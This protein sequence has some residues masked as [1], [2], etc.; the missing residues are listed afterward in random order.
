M[1]NAIQSCCLFLF[2]ALLCQGAGAFSLFAQTPDEQPALLFLPAVASQAGATRTPVPIPS[3][4]TTTRTTTLYAGPGNVDYGALTTLVTGTALT[5]LGIYG[6]FVQVETAAADTPTTGYLWRK[7]L[8]TLPASLPELTT[9]AVPWVERLLVPETYPLTF[10]LFDPDNYRVYPL[11][12]SATLADGDITLQVSLQAQPQS[13]A[14]ADAANG[15]Y[16]GTGER[17]LYLAYQGGN[18]KFIY[19]EGDTYP[20]ARDFPALTAPTVELTLKLMQQN[21]L[22]TVGLPTGEEVSI[23]LGQSLFAPD[24]TLYLFAQTAPAST[25]TLLAAQLVQ[26]PSGRYEE[27]LALA[28]PL[29]DLAGM[30]GVTLGTALDAGAL[31]TVLDRQ[32]LDRHAN[33]QV[34]HLGWSFSDT[35]NPLPNAYA[36]LISSTGVAFAKAH[37]KRVRA[38]PLLWYYDIPD[39]VTNGAYTPAELEEILRNR[40][41]SLMTK[42]QADEWVVINEAIV[43]EET[44]PDLRDNVFQRAFGEEHL[45]MAFRFARIADP[46]AILIYNDY[47]VEEI[48]TKSDRMYNLLQRMLARGVPIDGVGLQFHLLGCEGNQA[49]TKA[50]MLA[51]MARFADLGLDIYVTELDVNLNGLAGSKEAKWATQAQIYRDVT[52]ACLETAACQSVT[53]W[54]LRDNASWWYDV[55]GCGDDPLLFAADYTPKPAFFAVEQALQQGQPRPLIIDYTSSA[56]A[57][58]GTP[59]AVWADV[60]AQAITHALDGNPPV[61]AD[62]AGDFR[63]LYDGAN[64]Y[65]FV[66]VTDDIRRTDS[67]DQWWE[68]DAVELYLDGDK[69]R[70]TTYDG[71]NDFQL[72]FRPSAGAVIQGPNSAVPPPGI[73]WHSVDTATGYRVEMAIPL[74]AVGI[75]PQEGHEFGLDVQVMDDD[76]GDARDHKLAWHTTVDET[77]RNP[78]FFGAAQLAGAPATSNDRLLFQA[79]DYAAQS[80][81]TRT[82]HQ[83]GYL[84]DGD[85]I[86]F[87][88]V[89]LRRSYAIWRVRYGKGNDSDTRMELRLDSPTGLELA[90]IATDETGGWDQLVEDTIPLAAPAP[91]IYDLY[92]VFKG[93]EGVGELDWFALEE[94]NRVLEAEDFSAQQGVE[95]YATVVGYVDDGDWL[96]FDNVDLAAGYATLRVRYAK[97]NQTPTRLTVHLDA[98]TGPAI[99]ELATVNTGGWDTY[100][101]QSVRISSGRGLHTLYLHFTGGDGAGNFDRLTLIKPDLMPKTYYVNHTTGD[102]RNSGLTLATPFKR[103]QRAADRALPGDTVLVMDGLYTGR[104]QQEPVLHVTRS[105]RADA[106]ITFRA[107]PGHQP[108]L[109]NTNHWH[110]VYLDGAYLIFDGFAVRG[111]NDSFTLESARAHF[112]RFA[113]AGELDDGVHPGLFGSGI[114]AGPYNIIRNNTVFQHGGT[115]IGLL[116]TADYVIIEQNQVYE[117]SWYTAFGESGINIWQP[118]S[119]V[120]QHALDLGQTIPAEDTALLEQYIAELAPPSWPNHRYTMIIR[121]NTAYDNYNFFPCS[122]ANYERVSDGNGIILDLFDTPDFDYPPYQGRVLVENNLLFHNGGSGVRL[123]SVERA[124][125][126]NNVIYHNG[127]HPE[128][129]GET[130][131]I[132]NGPDTRFVNNI[133]VA[134]PGVA[135]T[136]D[137]NTRLPVYSD[138]NLY[139]AEDSANLPSAAMGPHDRIADPHFVLPSVDPTVAD[140]HLRAG[141]PAIDSGSSDYLPSIDREGVPRVA[142]L[143]NRGAYERVIDDPAATDMRKRN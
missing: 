92:V 129:S 80:G 130:F 28:D 36:E 105:G 79:E 32:L 119:L 103:I 5:P 141:S 139:A 117:N 72:I 112:E 91:G 42:H 132:D 86:R 18:W 6:D 4:V 69:S 25:T 43:D 48:N 57:I 53:T 108:L 61:A 52:E 82:E 142:G 133:I 126:L 76:D 31:G 89:D 97:G 106:Y 140:F 38:H 55:V 71:D 22:V 96:R 114:Y 73:Q 45:D 15:I 120:A 3:L 143:I 10:D 78:S 104:N 95:P 74:A 134:A 75:T 23:D 83:I 63:S 98:L 125:L 90:Q 62:L 26:A 122:C 131:G 60:P 113:F 64:L 93:G 85:W 11:F 116:R 109:Q 118:F 94:P 88:Q 13:S 54:G 115:G 135:V 16:F 39:W 121:N 50:A 101:E 51:N 65:V 107:Y 77:W 34:W 58:D 56:P 9:G 136:N 24:T 127:R 44:G 47:G 102:D 138:Y 111:M 67:G 99:A 8:T 68:D 59:D 84:D 7:A 33:L 110:T 35:N 128:A 29:R 17:R 12:G 137:G 87:D 46:D 37:G 2:L 41:T 123:V 19:G 49:P 66:E 1:R 40:I 124:D 81:V 100:V 21:R 20:I 70:G 30:R 27:V 14:P